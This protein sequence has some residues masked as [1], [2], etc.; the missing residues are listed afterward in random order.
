MITDLI[1]K[2]G[3]NLLKTGTFV[4]LSTIANQAVRDSSKETILEITKDIRRIKNTYR[5]NE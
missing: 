3:S 2:N 4:I 1:A 5:L